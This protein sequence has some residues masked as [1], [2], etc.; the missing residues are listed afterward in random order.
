[1]K[2]N[3]HTKNLQRIILVKKIF[4]GIINTNKNYKLLNLLQYFNK[5]HL[6]IGNAYNQDILLKIMHNQILNMQI[7][8]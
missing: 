1:M 2:Y 3:M 7:L 5:D 6:L 4:K 8:E